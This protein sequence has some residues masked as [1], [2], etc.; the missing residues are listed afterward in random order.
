MSMLLKASNR[1][2]GKTTE[3]R[4]ST[5]YKAPGSNKTSNLNN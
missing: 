2:S 4:G 3:G 1:A 5:F